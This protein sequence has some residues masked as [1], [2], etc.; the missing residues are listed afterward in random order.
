MGSSR[1]QHERSSPPRTKA[2]APTS[3]QPTGSPSSQAELS[4]PTTGMASV[5]IAAAV[6]GSMVTTLLC[7]AK[8]KISATVDGVEGGEDRR[9]R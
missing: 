1:Q 9:S 6:A 5:L 3:R 2:R 4:R 7:A 8:Q